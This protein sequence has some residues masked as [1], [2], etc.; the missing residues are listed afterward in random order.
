[1][2]QKL[3]KVQVTSTFYAIA[4]EGEQNDL[5]SRT[6][7]EALR[8]DFDK[9]LRISEVTRYEHLLDWE[10][11]ECGVYGE[12]DGKS[13]KEAFEDTTGLNYDQAKADMLLSYRQA[14]EIA[15]QEKNT[16]A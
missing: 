9:G 11:H 16:K 3:Y 13:L 2:A 6:V 14:K 4:E 5:S 10:D 7:D 15:Q 12:C 8:D 1:M